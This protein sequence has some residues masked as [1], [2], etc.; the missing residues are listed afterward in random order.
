MIAYLRIACG[1]LAATALLG[2]AATKSTT[3]S[4][5]AVNDPTCLTD[6]GS[7]IPRG[8]GQCRGVGRSY[9]S[10]DIEKTGATSAAEALSLLDSSVHH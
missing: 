3:S 10:Q 7:R 1:A 4:V 9:S 6:T 2:C 5:A 8:P